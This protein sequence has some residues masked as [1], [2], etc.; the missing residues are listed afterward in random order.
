MAL[1]VLLHVNVFMLHLLLFAVPQQRL[2]YCR[3]LRGNGSGPHI[4]LFC[5]FTFFDL[6][7]YRFEI[8]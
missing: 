6:V 4:A 7:M 2:L 3:L 1:E 8:Y 5:P